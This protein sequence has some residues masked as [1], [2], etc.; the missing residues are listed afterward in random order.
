MRTRPQTAPLDPMPRGRRSFHYHPP[1]ADLKGGGAYTGDD[2]TFLRVMSWVMATA[3]VRSSRATSSPAGDPEQDPRGNTA[4]YLDRTFSS[5][6]DRGVL[7][8]GMQ[9]ERPLRVPPRRTPH[10][11]DHHGWLMSPSSSMHHTA[12]SSPLREDSQWCTGYRHQQTAKR[13]GCEHLP[14]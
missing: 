7:A 13:H 12:T 1:A 3:R 5:F 14:G 11:S 2:I 6:L 4:L 8:E 9:H 10:D